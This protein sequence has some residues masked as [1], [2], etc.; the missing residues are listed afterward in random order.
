MKSRSGFMLLESLITMSISITILIT[1]SMCVGQQFK[2]LNYWEERVS[3]HKI[4]L[5]HSKTDNMDNE[6]I[7]DG[8]KYFYDNINGRMS[9]KVNGN[10]FYAQKA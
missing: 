3:A 2:I 5:I 8:K 1:L 6:H 4:M 9:V 10:I 7:V